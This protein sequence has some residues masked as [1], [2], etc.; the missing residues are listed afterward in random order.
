MLVRQARSVFSN[1]GTLPG[2]A[3]GNQPGNFIKGG[4]RNRMVGG[5]DQTFGG[6]ANGQLSPSSFVLPTKSGSISSYVEAS[7]SIT[8]NTVNIIIGKPMDGSST[9]TVTV[10]SASLDATFPMNA[11]GNITVTVNSAALAAAVNATAS[12]TITVAVDSAQLGGIFEVT[13]SGTITTTPDF[14]LTALAWIE[15]SAGGPTPL[16]PEGLADA[17]W[18]APSVDN[19]SP[20][21]MG[22][23]LNDA[24]AA[25]NPWSADLASNN[26][27]GTFG[28]FVQKL[29]TV[30]KFLGLK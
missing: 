10:T 14:E 9:I 21:T 15:A 5:L 22:E 16:S 3:F 28:G 18:S 24:G 19:N 20:G 6:Y 30:A 11:S 26:T 4:L 27:D 7:G 17:V 1:P 25:G 2:G 13:A 12:G 23:L 29:L 8:Q